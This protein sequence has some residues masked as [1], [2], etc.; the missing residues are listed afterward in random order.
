MKD[1]VGISIVGIAIV[2]MT[3]FFLCIIIIGVSFLLRI[4]SRDKGNA[5]HAEE[6]R[7]AVRAE[8]S[9]SFEHGNGDGDELIAVI[10]A[11]VLASME[12]KPECRIQVK[13]VRRIPQASP[14]WNLAGRTELLSDKL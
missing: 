3:L 5:S 8:A 9:E 1:A 6:V 2:L 12:K 13:S 11:A 14:V 10:T 4:C 7:Q